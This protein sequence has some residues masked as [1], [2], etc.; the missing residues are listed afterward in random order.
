MFT[1]DAR[2]ISDFW[3]DFTLS[4]INVFLRGLFALPNVVLMYFIVIHLSD[5]HI[6]TNFLLKL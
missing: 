5:F 2:A 1:N 4:F 6:K 3:Q